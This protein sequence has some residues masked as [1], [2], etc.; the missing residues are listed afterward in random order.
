[1]SVLLL[2]S[3]RSFYDTVPAEL[4]YSFV[5]YKSVSQSTWGGRVIPSVENV[6]PGPKFKS[7]PVFLLSSQRP[8]LALPHFIPLSRGIK[9]MA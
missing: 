2:G 8:G 9:T 7:G 6:F 5:A 4:L 1:M 3:F